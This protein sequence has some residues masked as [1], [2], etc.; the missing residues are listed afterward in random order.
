MKP[1]RT[2][3]LWIALLLVPL[4]GAPA[5]ALDAKG[6][7][8]AGRAEAQAKADAYDGPP[9]WYARTRVATQ[10]GPVVNHYWSKGPWL[11]SETLL[12]GHRVVTIVNATH[13]HVFDLVMGEGTSIERGPNAIASDA[14]RGRPFGRELDELIAAGGEKIHQGI[15]ENGGVPYQV[16]QLTNQNGRRRI[17]VTDSDPPLPI[18]VETF[19]RTSGHNGMLE[20]SGWLRDMEI[21]D[22]FFEPPAHIE[23]KRLSYAEYLKRAPTDS[24]TPAPIYFRH[25]LH[26]N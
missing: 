8:G 5:S 25:L 4:V 17:S 10:F 20:Y 19:V 12:A 14:K 21:A 6:K 23:W 26:G 16:Y 2:V 22:S 3:P 7:K 24:L 15:S 11:R 1:R 18:L 9:T 13:Y